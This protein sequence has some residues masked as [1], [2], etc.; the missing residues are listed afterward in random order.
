MDKY[1]S[2]RTCR[3]SAIGLPDAGPDLFAWAATRIVCDP[4]PVRLPHGA[5]YIARR[6]GCPRHLA[7]VYAEHAGFSMEPCE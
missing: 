7:R 4:L 5:D 1:H 6:F 3:K 2:R